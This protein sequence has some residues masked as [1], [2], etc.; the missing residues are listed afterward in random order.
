MLDNEVKG[1]K[2]QGQKVCEK[3]TE[4]E[5]SSLRVKEKTQQLEW[6]VKKLLEYMRGS[7]AVRYIFFC[8]FL[9]L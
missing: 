2:L 6:K 8:L 5:R 1:R 4:A 9:S 3:Q 7:Q